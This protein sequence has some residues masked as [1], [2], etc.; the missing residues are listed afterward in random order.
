M[1]EDA[2]GNRAAHPDQL[3]QN[4]EPTFYKSEFVLCGAITKADMHKVLY[5]VCLDMYG[6]GG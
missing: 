3:C 5:V 1:S 4:A 6:K 2:S